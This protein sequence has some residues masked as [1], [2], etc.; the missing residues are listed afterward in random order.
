MKVVIFGATGMVGQLLTQAALDAGHVVVALVRSPDKLGDL[1]KRI[2]VIEGEY[3]DVEAQRQTLKGADAVLTTIGPPRTRAK[4]NGEYTKAMETLI[5]VMEAELVSRI[6]SLGGAA[7][8]LGD[9]KLNFSSALMRSIFNLT[10]GAN[11]RDKENEQNI[12]FQSSLDWTLIRPPQISKSEGVFTSTFDKVGGWKVDTQ[13]LA[14]YM[15]AILTDR[16][17][18]RT[19]PFVATV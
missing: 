1:A 11:Y 19:A 17:T 16:A 10:S 12:L 2:S 14:E 6:V 8:K 4:N 3:F 15:V 18:F 5:S 13:Q 7:I 9:D